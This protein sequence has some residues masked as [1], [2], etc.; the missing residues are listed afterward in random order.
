MASQEGPKLGLKSTDEGVTFS[1]D[2]VLASMGGWLGILESVIPGVL[3]MLSYSITKLALPSVILASLISLG[4]IVYRVAKKGKLSQAVV[5]A[6][7]VAL[8]A[9]L[10]LRDGGEATDYFIPG[11][12]INLTYGTVMLLSVV[13]RW[14]IIGL[15]IGLLTSSGTQWRK[16]SSLLKTYNFATLVWVGLF[17]LRLIVE[18]PLYF[19]GQLEALTAVKIVLG[20]PAYALTAWISWLMVRK[21]FAKATPSDNQEGD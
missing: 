18:L 14:P 20:Y 17:S 7:F 9:F 6:A 4:F 3:F 13:V 8:S 19:A 12:L 10:V 5:G 11:I 1:K 21:T 15:L 2:A 16:D